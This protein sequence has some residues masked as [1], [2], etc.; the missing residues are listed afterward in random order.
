M[1]ET[2]RQ[3]E[4]RERRQLMADVRAVAAT[5][6]GMRVLRYLLAMA[7]LYRPTF[8][9]DNDRLSA[10]R[11]GERNAGLRL[12]ALLD[13]ADESLYLRIIQSDQEIKQ[14]ER[15]DRSRER[16]N[17]DDDGADRVW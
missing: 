15:I 9:A 5:A 10:F 6:E 3:R 11:E 1:A 14:R 17:R 12:L 2:Q 16:G 7:G 8:V 13:E 4:A